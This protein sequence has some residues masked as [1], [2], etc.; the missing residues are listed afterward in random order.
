MPP[1]RKAICIRILEPLG[2]PTIAP[3]FIVG[4]IGDRAPRVPAGTTEFWL[5][6]MQ[7]VCR[8]CRGLTIIF[9]ILH[10]TMNRWAI[11]FRPK[12]SGT[13]SDAEAC[14]RLCVGMPRHAK[15]IRMPTPSRGHGTRKVRCDGPTSTKSACAIVQRAGGFIPPDRG[16]TELAEVR[17]KPGGSCCRIAH[18]HLAAPRQSDDRPRGARAGDGNEAC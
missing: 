9:R 2:R 7:R 10:P 15:W 14:P 17:D 5:P 11:L 4:K 13:D 3:R 12:G 16:S 18:R 6:A 8:P 1:D